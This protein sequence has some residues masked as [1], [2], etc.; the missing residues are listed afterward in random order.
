MES[1]H[2]ENLQNDN[3]SV[4][5]WDENSQ[6]YFHAS[7]GFYH[8]PSAGWYYSSKDGLY[9]KFED[10]N[11]VLLSSNEADDGGTFP[12]NDVA[13]KDP[14]LPDG[15][16]Q[17][18]Y[19]ENGECYSTFAESISECHQQMG[20]A[21][22]VSHDPRDCMRSPTSEKPPPPPSEWLEDT[23]I[24]LYLSG[25]NN[26]A[27]SEADTAVMPL[28]TDDEAKL[29]SDGTHNNNTYEL[30][31]GE[32]IPEDENGIANT[33]IDEDEEKWRA[34]YGQVI[35]SG[36][37][38][39]SEFPA[40][41]VWEWEMVRGSRKDGKDEVARLVGRLVKRSI[42]LHPSMPSGGGKLR[43]APICE[44]HLDLVRVKTGQVYKLRNPNASYLA[45]L[46]TY[47][48]A[49]P[50]KE[51]G[52]PPL[53]SDWKITHISK[54]SESSASVSGG[55]C[56]EKGLPV[57]PNQLAASKQRSCQYRD[58]AAERRM[59]HGVFSVGPGQKNPV[60]SDNDT[61]SS[62]VGNCPQEAAAEALEIS[63]GSGSY[64]RKILKSMGWKEGE[65]LGS[66]TKGLLEPIQPVG[67]IGNAGL[68]WSHRGK[69]R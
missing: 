16:C 39:V 34:Q 30:E 41:D 13:P 20:T 69:K 63:F 14:T 42:K 1:D 4:F 59:L 11:Y 66:S 51:W 40:V 28:E 9:Y 24:D 43:S 23:L 53:S 5:V 22:E 37:E 38:V 12:S 25:Y 48:S 35:D 3:D 31:E 68:G 29:A 47:D 44:A 26:P 18:I 6:L 33:I 52:F 64:A 67:N 45:S 8:D 54:S 61:P 36:K 2:P 60:D 55:V 65:R 58:R 7:S 15:S 57:L 56:N 19:G 46:S 27:I 62:P 49:N 21:D 10:G 17:Q 50:T 32:W